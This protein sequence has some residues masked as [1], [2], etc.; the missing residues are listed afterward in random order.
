MYERRRFF[1]GEVF[2]WT[3]ALTVAVFKLKAALVLFAW[4]VMFVRFIMMSGNW[5][6]HAFIKDNRASDNWVAAIVIIDSKYNARCFNDGY[7]ILHHRHPS[8]HYT[9]LPA[10]YEKEKN[11]LRDNDSVIFH[12]LDYFGIWGLLMLKRYDILASFFVDLR[13]EEKRTKQDIASLLR[14]RTRA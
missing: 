8:C 2:Y 6:Q 12:T 1:V 14:S 9:E 5:A 7:H 4:P 3:L 13:P 10:F 11:E